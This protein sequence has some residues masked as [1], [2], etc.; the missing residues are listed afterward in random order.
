MSTSSNINSCLCAGLFGALAGVFLKLTFDAEAALQAINRTL[1]S[2][3][4]T[5]TWCLRGSCLPA[6][7]L[8]NVC[9]FHFFNRALQTSSASLQATVVVTAANLLITVIW[10]DKKRIT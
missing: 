8:S 1:D 10:Q 5:L 2:D 6:V 7:V 9:M 4:E 3:S